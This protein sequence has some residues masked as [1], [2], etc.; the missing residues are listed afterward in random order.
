M[1][2]LAPGH[3]AN[4]EQSWASMDNLIPLTT[5]PRRGMGLKP[6]GNPGFIPRIIKARMLTGLRVSPNLSMLI[7]NLYVFGL[8]SQLSLF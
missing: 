7:Y 5:Q 2:V 8:I 4:H 1:K 6:P 3:T